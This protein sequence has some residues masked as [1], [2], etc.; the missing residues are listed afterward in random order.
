MPFGG[1]LTVG[2]IG[3]GSSI[4]GGLIGSHAA[5]SAADKQAES[6]ANALAFQKSV[7]EDQKKNAAPY[8]AA[9]TNALST[10]Q[11]DLPSLTAGFDPTKQ[12]LSAQFDPNAPGGPGAAFDPTKAGVPAQ[13]SYGAKDFQ[14]DPGYQFALDEG[15]KAIQ[16]SGAA[17]GAGMGGAA[18]K[19]ATNFATGLAGQQ[20]QQAFQRAQSTYDT[21]YGNA[22]NTYK[23]NY[24]NAL[25]TYQQNY[26]NAFNT[27]KSNQSDAFG[28]LNSLVGTGLNANN[29]QAN[30][31]ANFAN[32]AGQYT[33]GAGNALAAGQ[34]GSANAISGAL[35]GGSNA[36]L[37][38]Y[39]A[40]KVYGGGGGG[41][42]VVSGF[43][44]PPGGFDLQAYLAQTAP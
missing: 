38:A 42:Q 13:F 37:N 35:S 14:A 23:L 33:I 9:G 25:G 31:G 26:G 41:S 6:A 4:A 39:L 28:R 8:L 12:G 11:A 19:S 2:L 43:D 18:I 20:Y 5:K 17:R 29:M 30:A 32:A 27:Y 1:L 10:L 44:T 16:R 36:L 7:Y 21:N 40:N 22:F 34:V 24:G 3:A 15:L